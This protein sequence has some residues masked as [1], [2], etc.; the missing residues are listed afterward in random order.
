M[1]MKVNLAFTHTF[2][3][4]IE[5]RTSRVQCVLE[6]SSGRMR[7]EEGTA[8]ERGAKKGLRAYGPMHC[9]PAGV[10]LEEGALP[11]KLPSF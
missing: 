2:I 11:V 10:G 3:E 5:T 8:G 7:S 4:L 1:C 9:V 6:Y